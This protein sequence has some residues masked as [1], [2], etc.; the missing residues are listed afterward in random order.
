MPGTVKVCRAAQ[1]VRWLDYGRVSH[2]SLGVLILP[3]VSHCEYDLHIVVSGSVQNVVQ[4]HKCR[5]IVHTYTTM[6]NVIKILATI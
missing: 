6:I 5:L 2:I 1:G 4:R 3:V